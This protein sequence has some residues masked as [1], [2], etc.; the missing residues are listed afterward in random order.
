[1]KH[2]KNK[3]ITKSIRMYIVKK[4]ESIIMEQGI[5]KIKLFGRQKVLLA[6]LQVF[7]GKMPNVNMQKYLFLF[8]Q[9]CEKDKSYEFVPYKYGCFSFQSYADRRKLIELG[10]VADVDNWELQNKEHDF[11]QLVPSDISKK[12]QLF[13]EKYI[14]LK[15]KE[16]IRE[17]YVKYPYYAINSEIANDIMTQEE[18]MFV[19]AEKEKTEELAFFTIGYEGDSFENYL[20]R[21]IRNNV[22]VLC[23]VRKNPL[24]RKYGFSKKALS[25]TLNKLGIDYIH[26]PELGIVSDKRQKLST[27]ADYDKLFLEYEKNTLKNSTQHLD[28]LFNVYQEYRRVAITCFEKEHCMCHRSKVAK[29]LESRPDFT[30]D[31]QHI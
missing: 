8:T 2:K 29:A 1:M 17:V 21:L 14:L 5:K 19:D 20:N 26:I 12:I 24:S 25:E 15:G 10:V 28:M 18:M 7:G 11:L 13:K 6:L 27:Q 31:I 16:L 9:I 4:V 3:E 22:K 23:D 30:V